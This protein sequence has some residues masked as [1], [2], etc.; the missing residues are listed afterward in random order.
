MIRSGVASILGFILLASAALAQSHSSQDYVNTGGGSWGW[1]Q[2]PKGKKTG[3]KV[4]TQTV[5]SVEYF[6]LRTGEQWIYRV[7]KDDPSLDAA[8]KANLERCEQNQSGADIEV[9]DDGSGP[10]VESVTP[11]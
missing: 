9:S 4:V 2:S 1:V 5:G 10:T 3:A 8:E 7:R 6:L 11:T